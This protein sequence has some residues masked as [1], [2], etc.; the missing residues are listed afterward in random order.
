M[1]RLL[2]Y[3]M[4]LIIPGC[5]STEKE[6]INLPEV[7]LV[8]LGIAQD[9]GYPQAGCSKS[10]C[11]PAWAGEVK[12]EKVVSLGIVDRPNNKVWMFE[13]TPD[14]KDQLHNLLDYLPNPDIN[15]LAGIFLSHAHM[16]HYTGLMHLGHEAMGAN[17]VP[18][19]AMP[20][21]KSFLE[22]NGPW[23]QLVEFNNINIKPLTADSMV[24][25]TSKIRVQP[26]L[27]PHRDEFS[28][29]VGYKI[30]VN[31]KQILFIPDIDKWSKWERD[32]TVE[33]EKVDFAF[34]DASF[35][36]KDELPNRDM[37]E[38]GH[39]FVPETIELFKS[40][41]SET[42]KK[43]IFIHF[44]HTNKLI[45]SGRDYKLIINQGYNIA[46]EGKIYS[47]DQ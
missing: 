4:L 29:T 28:E 16:G 45:K 10:C 32:I 8:V 36:K 37:S 22:T 35:Y 2:F 12:Y 14:F 9:A 18:V 6:V 24:N 27:V 30:T 17:K 21:M 19:Y 33:V 7:F 41:A 46:R 47:L 13:A 23:S 39:P 5:I 42:R 11:A 43:V 15:S 31:K 1:K 3:I 20:R 26:F 34:L 44:N 40:T 25:L 38:I